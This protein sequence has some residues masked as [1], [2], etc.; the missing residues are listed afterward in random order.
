LDQPRRASA[1]KA[2]RNWELSAFRSQPVSLHLEFPFVKGRM[3]PGQRKHLD[4]LSGPQFLKPDLDPVVE[5]QFVPLAAKLG[6]GLYEYST[7][8]VFQAVFR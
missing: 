7:F 3:G 1:L 8:L 6:A 4:K 5:S 2:R